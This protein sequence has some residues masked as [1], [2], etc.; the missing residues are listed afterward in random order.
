MRIE[1][2]KIGIVVI[3]VDPRVTE[4]RIDVT[5]TDLDV[6]I[7][8]ISRSHEMNAGS[9]QPRDAP[10]KEDL[11]ENGKMNDVTKLILPPLDLRM[12][13][14]KKNCLVQTIWHIR[15]NF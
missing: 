11:V 5:I 14:L 12:N 7:V 10:S 13:V 15:H 3:V 4:D 9:N 8:M 1:E 2:A 6:L